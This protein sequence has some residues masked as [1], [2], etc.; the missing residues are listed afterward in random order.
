MIVDQF[1]SIKSNYFLFTVV[2]IFSFQLV[3]SAAGAAHGLTVDRVLAMVGGEIITFTEY[4]LFVKGLEG[5]NKDEVDET[6]LR[7]LIE[8]KII[9]Q[10]AKRKGFDASDVEVQ[11]MVEEFK[12]E[13]GLSNEDM[14]SFLREEGLNVNNYQQI[15]RGKVLLSKII[16]SEVDSKV[17]VRDEEIK[18]SYQKNKK[19]FLSGPQKVEVKAIFLKLREDASVTEITDLK[20]RALRIMTLLRDGYNFDSLIAEYSD[21]P[22]KSQ[23]GMLGKFAKGSLIPSLDDKAFSMK[24]GEISDPIWVSEGVYI[25]HLMS[26]SG[27]TFKP[28]D[29]VKEEIYSSLYKQKRNRI[30]NEWIKALWEK[31]SLIINQN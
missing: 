17:I 20:L 25:L 19:E 12:T 6:L 18:E 3:L 28:Y 26:K 15:L 10:E 4:K 8:E 14:E 27:E 9:I 24:E 23:G 21:E 13:N 22:L 1:N 5:E 31:A 29:E 7:K 16:S 11:K 2:V 30:Y